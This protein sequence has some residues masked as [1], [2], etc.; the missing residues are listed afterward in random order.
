MQIVVC[1]CKRRR[2]LSE[3]QNSRLHFEQDTEARSSLENGLV[4]PC[5]PQQPE[6]QP[7]ARRAFAGMQEALGRR[8]DKTWFKTC[9]P[10]L[11][12]RGFPTAHA[13]PFRVAFAINFCQIPSSISPEGSGRRKPH[14]CM[15]L[16]PRV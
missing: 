2:R 4:R 16:S 6:S 14:Q 12:L 1:A 8:S 3:L 9:A 11:M 10:L 7:L 13:F 15:S 5:N